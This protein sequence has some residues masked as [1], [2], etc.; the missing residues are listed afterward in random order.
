ML[1]VMAPRTGE[2]NCDESYR[3]MEAKGPSKGNLRRFQMRCLDSCWPLQ[4]P[5][6]ATAVA[7]LL[8][9]VVAWR[10]CCGFNT[11]LPDV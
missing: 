4:P 1:T 9:G 3:T 2:I 7:L 6:L 11:P 10:C 5:P 8:C